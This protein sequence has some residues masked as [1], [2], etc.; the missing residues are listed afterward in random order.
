MSSNQIRQSQVLM[1]PDTARSAFASAVYFAFLGYSHLAWADGELDSSFGRNGVVNI[2]FPNS[3]RGYLYD[4]A[5]VNGS[6]EAAGFERID[7]SN[8]CA[9]PFPNLFVVRLSLDGVVIGT[10]HSRTQQAIVARRAGHR[11][12]ERRHHNGGYLR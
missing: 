8:R 10:T 11:S 12:R 9:T 6:I 5:V 3:S 4:A 1:K 2:A 7:P